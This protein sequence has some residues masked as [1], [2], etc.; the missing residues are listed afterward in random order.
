MHPVDFMHELAFDKHC[1]P[2]VPPAT[3]PHAFFRVN[4][5]RDFFRPLERVSQELFTMESTTCNDAQGRFSSGLA[6]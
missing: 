3:L 2:G 6:V 1:A 4:F 5:P